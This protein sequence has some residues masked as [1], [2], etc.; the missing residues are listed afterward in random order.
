MIGEQEGSAALRVAI[1]VP[2]RD[3]VEELP[4]LFAALAR[5]TYAAP[6][7]LCLLL[8]S[9]RDDS[10]AVARAAA[11]HALF[12]VVIEEAAQ[13]AA[14]AG[15]A[16]HGAML[17]GLRTL[18][19]R[20]GVL[21]TTDADSA[22]APDWVTAMMAGLARADVVAGRVLRVVTRPNPL[23]D[24]LERYYEA[25]YALRRSLD[26][27]AWEGTVTHHHASGANLGLRADTYRALG[28]FLPLASGEDARLVD[29]AGRAGLRVRRDA[30]A[31][32]Y[33]SDRRRGRAEHGL[34]QSLLAL[35]RGDGATVAHPHDAAWQYRCHALARLAFS[36]SDF[37]ALAGVIGLSPDHALGV[38]R[39]CPNAEAFAMRVVPTPPHGVRQVPLVMAEAELAAMSAERRAA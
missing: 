34:A 35:D 27:V 32:V 10:L 39:D 5:L 30:A 25:L 26:P 17:L 15:H 29:D 18:G 9:C 37:T 4:R 23:Q 12:P 20:P 11:A 2:A 8:D 38:A 14:N 28:G 3:E 1:C 22:P 33:T 36:S 21:L 16:R 31:I 6:S 7:T 13:P 24:R 19:E